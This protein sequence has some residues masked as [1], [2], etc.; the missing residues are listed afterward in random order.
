LKTTSGCNITIEHFPS[1]I[2]VALGL[3]AL[4]LVPRLLP[5][6]EEKKAD[7][8][9][10]YEL[11]LQKAEEEY[12]RFFEKPRKPYEF[13]TAMRFELDT[14]KFDLA[15]LHL[16]LL[17]EQP[18]E[19]ADKDLVKIEEAQGM[20]AFLRLRTIKKWS[21]DPVIQTDAVKNVDLLIDRVT[22][23]LE[24]HL[25]DPER[26]RK[27]IKNLDAKTI[28]ERTFAFYQLERSRERAVPY[29][30]EALQTTTGA[31]RAKVK[32][33]MVSLPREIVPAFLEVLK[34]RNA[35][36]AGQEEPRLTLL[37]IVHERA[38]KRAVPYLWH[39]SSAT[40][41]PLGVRAQARRTLIYLL[42]TEADKLPP[43]KMPLTDL[44][45]QHY[46]HKITFLEARLT[47]EERKAFEEAH[48]KQ[49]PI[50]QW[51]WDGQSL[52]R[53]LEP[54]PAVELKFGLRYAREAL[55]LDPAYLPAQIVFLN[56]T[57]DRAFAPELD[58]ALFKGTPPA[59][60]R[61]LATVDSDLLM[62]VLERALDEHKVSVILP[63]LQ[64]LGERGEVRAARPQGEGPPRGIV[65]ALYY[66]DRRV[67]F[68][69]VQ[70]MLR[71]PASPTPVASVRIVDILR[72]LVAADSTPRALLAF[73]PPDRVKDFRM[74]LKAAG[75]ETKSVASMKESLQN[76]S[77][78]A[79]FDV[80]LLHEAGGDELPHAVAQ[81]R[82]DRDHG[83]LPLLLVA[84]KDRAE[85]L[86]RLAERYPGVDVVSEVEATGTELKATLDRRIAEASGAKLTTQERKKLAGDALDALWRM[87]RGEY[88]GYDIRPAQD[89]LVSVIAKRDED[90]ALQALEILGRL[91]GEAAQKQLARA[92]LDPAMGKLRNAAARE[93]NRHIQKHSLLLGAD[94]LQ[95]ARILFA[96]PK[97]DPDLRSQLALVIGSL[98]PSTAQTGVRLQDF[99]PDPPPPPKKEEKKGEKG[100]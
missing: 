46:L 58:K 29:L 77:H 62:R 72:R 65:R 89:A 73:A 75:F 92:S 15:A 21:D 38:D 61:L 50:V 56:L 54:L 82:A 90:L 18:K 83:R 11:L 41:Y 93:L 6:Q 88:R 63:A 44:A 39:L 71:M 74:A 9:K 7:D 60:Q 86:R 40:R 66:P 19:E 84:G 2:T 59:L 99:Q 36:D 20:F 35:K 97:E 1:R 52:S 96:S 4:L 45:E 14:G 47:K 23:A 76:L 68:G 32:A 64:A 26:L 33:A 95:Q 22:T 81:L 34:A 100:E 13:W 8:K 53:K 78:A 69:A 12:R 98:R 94:Q 10:A 67:H 17:L 70:A 79:D 48:P 31:L 24:K 37:E 27:F 51:E 3:A 57:L 85:S 43:A 30:I 49:T 28:E 42:E 87:A 55:D 5:A 91:P 25:S 16:K 80:L